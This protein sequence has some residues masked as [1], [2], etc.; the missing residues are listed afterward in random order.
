MGRTRVD[1]GVMAQANSTPRAAGLTAGGERDRERAHQETRR[2][3]DSLRA[4]ANLDPRASRASTIS[5][6]TPASSPRLAVSGRQ[7]NAS[8]PLQAS[9]RE[10]DLAQ[11]LSVDA[12]VEVL[13]DGRSLVHQANSMPAT[14]R[15]A[16]SDCARSQLAAADSPKLAA[17]SNGRPVASEWELIIRPEWP[18]ARVRYQ[19]S[20]ARAAPAVSGHYSSSELPFSPESYRV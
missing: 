12:N 17:P 7:S 18:R 9:R 8:G 6:D 4:R 5:G 19:H 1:I 20:D 13:P 3:P 15:T 11:P 10:T 16:G 2:V 14:L